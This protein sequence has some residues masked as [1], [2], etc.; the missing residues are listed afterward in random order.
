ME[1]LKIEHVSK[2]L[3]LEFIFFQN[4]KISKELIKAWYIHFKNCT[5]EEFF[6]GVH[7]AVSKSKGFPPVPG[8]VWDIIR[9]L[10]CN[11]EMLETADQAW[12]KAISKQPMTLRG[13]TTLDTMPEFKRR[14]DWAS[15]EIHWKKKEFERIYNQ[16]KEQDDILETQN[17]ARTSI[18]YGR[19]ELPENLK[20]LIG[21]MYVDNLIE[22]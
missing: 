9:Q 18:G 12:A 14:Q 19:A 1:H 21:G 15:D 16:L 11:P 3:T 8:E 22:A 7:L 5:V 4:M 20:K 2:I 13:Q 6:S 10:R 17:I